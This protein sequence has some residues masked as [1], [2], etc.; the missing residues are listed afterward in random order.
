[1][2][3]E[4]V[5]DPEAI[6][7]QKIGEFRNHMLNTINKVKS[8]TDRDTP[9]IDIQNYIMMKG[10][11]KD[12]HDGTDGEDMQGVRRDIYPG[13]ERGHFQ[14]YLD[15]LEA[16]ERE[17][18]FDKLTRA[19][20]IEMPIDPLTVTEESGHITSVAFEGHEIKFGQSVRVLRRGSNTIEDGWKIAGFYRDSE[21]GIRGLVG[22]NNPSSPSGIMSKEVPIRDLIKWQK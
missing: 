16:V 19:V 10:Q 18:G 12:L 8:G 22:A 4:Q 1:M 20:D 9:L 13:F 14:T 17:T 11:I 6:I 15:R 5:K 3:M 7:E 2:T 21:H